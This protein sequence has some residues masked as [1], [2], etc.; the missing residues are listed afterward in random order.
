[1][2]VSYQHEVS[3][4]KPAGPAQTHGE[5]GMVLAKAWRAA[6]GVD[7]RPCD[8]PLPT[9]TSLH[10]TFQCCVVDLGMCLEAF[11]TGRRRLC[12]KA[13]AESRMG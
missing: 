3:R 2:L 7:A 8:I 9:T 5:L 1:M 6:H 11:F 12:A 10:R 4:L 13:P